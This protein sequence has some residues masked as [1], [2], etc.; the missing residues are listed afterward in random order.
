MTTALAISC[1]A[2]RDQ[3]ITLHNELAGLARTSLER[4]QRIG[5]L[6]MEVRES[7]G[8]GEWLPWIEANLPF[9]DRTARN[10]IRLHVKRDL[11]KLENVSD[12]A[13]AYR[14]LTA[15]TA[16]PAYEPLETEALVAESKCDVN[17]LKALGKR[18]Q[19]PDVTLP[20]VKAFFDFA[21]ERGL[22]WH[23]VT[24][25]AEREIGNFL[26]SLP[27]DDMRAAWCKDPLGF[28]AACERKIRELEAPGR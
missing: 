10:Y 23:G 19:S 21:T 2:K 13:G 4:A 9:T 14:L 20:E 25:D 3:I 26:N 24:I 1:A 7:L 12:L 11:L 16:E 6:L 22:Y 15:E 27:N 18:L 8:H 5:R 28:V 17:L